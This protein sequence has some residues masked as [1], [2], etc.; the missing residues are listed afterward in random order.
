MSEK[1]V[2]LTR[3]RP[4]E[5]VDLKD[6]TQLRAHAARLRVT[7]NELREMAEEAAFRKRRPEPASHG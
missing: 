7:V 4:G 5:G 3:D 6:E 2:E 1:L